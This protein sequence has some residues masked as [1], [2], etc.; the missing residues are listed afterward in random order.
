M[1]CCDATL[2]LAH[3]QI[4]GFKPYKNTAFE[5][6]FMGDGH[7]VQHMCGVV[8]GGGLKCWGRNDAGE[9]T[10]P[11]TLKVRV[12]SSCLAEHPEEK[13]PTAC[14]GCAKDIHHTIIDPRTNTGTCTKAECPF[15][16]PKACCGEKHKHYVVNSE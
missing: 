9:A 2:S 16:K 4:T 8:K 7:R 15:C 10:V 13:G 12:E 14:T 6:L 11:S 5:A 1:Q 3:Y